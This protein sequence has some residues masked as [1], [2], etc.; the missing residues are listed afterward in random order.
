[1]KSTADQI[2][3]Y[4]FK[5][6]EDSE[7]GMIDLQ[8]N[9][10]AQLFSCVPSQINYVIA[11]RFTLERGYVIESKRGGGGYIRIRRVTDEAHSEL[12]PIMRAIGSQI[13]QREAEGIVWRMESDG[14]LTAREAKMMRAV[15]SRDVIHMPLPARDELRA[16]LFVAMLVAVLTHDGEEME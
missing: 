13:S 7:N 15:L 14:I 3:A 10:L 2:E 1:M 5:R 4:L 16:R 12:D 9:E 11:T 8:R 6:I